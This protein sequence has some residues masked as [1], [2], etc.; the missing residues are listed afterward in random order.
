MASG[1]TKVLCDHAHTADAELRISSLWALK[2]LVDGAP[3][4]LKMSC[5]EELGTGWLI[6]TL[7]GELSGP[8]RSHMA[9][10]NAAGEQVDILNSEEE[11]GMDLDEAG[12]SSSDDDSVSG[13]LR[14]AFEFSS[15]TGM[16][17]KDRNLRLR[18]IK[19]AESNT[20]L[21]GYRDDIRTQEQALDFVR[22]LVGEPGPG[23]PDMVEHV[24]SQLGTTRFFEIIVG[25]L[26]PKPFPQ[27]A[28]LGHGGLAPGSPRSYTADM[29]ANSAQPIRWQPPEL[30]ISTL[31]IL[32]HVA[33][34]RPSHRQLLI[35]QPSLLDTLRPVFQHPD[36]RIRVACCWLVH[37]LLWQD[38]GTDKEGCRQRAM[39][40]RIKGVEECVRR[41]IND[42]D[43][44]T[45]ERAK[46]VV[47]YFTRLLDMRGDAAGAPGTGTS[48]TGGRSWDR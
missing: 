30:L 38:D 42:E 9:T 39:E 41:L 35:N 24:F 46:G 31:F 1:V 48:A 12:E 15:L 10:S 27:T 28:R 19:A 20:A 22:N 7:T 3:N 32:I 40:L 43:L 25:K 23:Q 44:D 8:H 16:A 2:H 29:Q 11:P 45:R 33:N 37:N 5:L 21:K 13:H 47:D 4:E 14:P 18:A 6:Q 34:G 26:K 17:A 36:R